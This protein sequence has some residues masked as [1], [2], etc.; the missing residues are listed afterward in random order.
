MEHFKNADNMMKI[1]QLKQDNQEG[2]LEMPDLDSTQDS[3]E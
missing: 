2:K 1:R 3:N